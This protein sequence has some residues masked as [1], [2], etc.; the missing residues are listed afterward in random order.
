MPQKMYTMNWIKNYEKTKMP[1]P[2]LMA[3]ALVNFSRKSTGKKTKA[4]RI[5]HRL[6]KET[7]PKIKCSKRKF[8]P[9]KTYEKLHANQVS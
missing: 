5:A 4:D 1:L 8:E 9:F 7:R 3:S 2:F 6:L